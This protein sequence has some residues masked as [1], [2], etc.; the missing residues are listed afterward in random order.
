MM[1]Y[2][3]VNRKDLTITK[4][5]LMPIWMVGLVLLLFNLGFALYHDKE[6]GYSGESVYLFAEKDTFNVDSL[7]SY[8]VQLNIRFL[9]VAIAQ[10]KKETGNYKSAIFKESNNLF[11]MKFAVVRPRTAIG[12]L[13]GHALYRNWRE[14]CIDY[15]LFQARYAGKIKT[16]EEYLQFIGQIYAEDPNYLKDLSRMIK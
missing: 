15:A 1:K 4:K 10:S 7:E 11:G 13:R 2:N 12:E 6:L 3:V 9:D 16:K 5:I 8:L 14:S